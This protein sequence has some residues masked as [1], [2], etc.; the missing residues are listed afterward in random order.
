MKN[1]EMNLRTASDDYQFLLHDP[2]RKYE[3]DVKA[4]DR[5]LSYS[6]V[7]PSFVV[8]DVGGA[9]GVDSFPFAKFCALTID[10]DIDGFALKNAKEYAKKLGLNSKICFIK[11]SA[12]ELPLKSESLDMITCFSVLDHLPNKPS[13]YKAIGEFSR[14]IRRFCY[15]VITVP[16]KLFLIGTVAMKANSLTN[17]NLFFEQR[18]T[19]KELWKVLTSSKL[20]P[21]VFDSEYP[22]SVGSGI[23]DHFPRLFKKMPRFMDFLVVMSKIFRW[24]KPVSCVK[25]FGARTGYLSQKR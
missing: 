3:Y 25:L 12:T 9:K 18:F 7:K 11:A 4:V 8:C 6:L 23:L 24:L 13:A 19:P 20:E 17:P 5:R 10:V 2:K 22:I 21:L 14:A 16:N 15:V 1:E